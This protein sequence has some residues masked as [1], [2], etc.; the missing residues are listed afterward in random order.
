MLS[1]LHLK[2]YE[3]NAANI[4]LMFTVE[5]DIVAVELQFHYHAYQKYL[6][7]VIVRK[8]MKTMRST[9]L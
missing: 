8:T 1:A 5:I 4:T 6:T 9:T 2:G 3:K 7:K